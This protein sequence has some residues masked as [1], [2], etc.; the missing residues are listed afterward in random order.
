MGVRRKL[1]RRDGHALVACVQA[2]LFSMMMSAAGTV[3]ALT[4]HR[5]WDGKKV[6]LQ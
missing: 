1:L 3:G 2:F 4:L 6:Q 5:L